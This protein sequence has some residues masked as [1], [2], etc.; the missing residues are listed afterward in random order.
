[1]LTLGIHSNCSIL[2]TDT[3]G[4]ASNTLAVTTFTIINSSGGGILSTQ[5]TSH[6]RGCLTGESFD[7][8]TGVRCTN[9]GPSLSKAFL[10][11]KNLKPGQKNTDI[12]E[13]QKYLNAHGFAV[14]LTGPGSLGNETEFFGP[15]T[16]KALI[17]F[18]EKYA[19]EIL[20]PIGLSKGTGSFATMTR[21]F[22][23]AH[24]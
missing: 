11:T 24:Q 7:R 4:N 14:A 10:F 8:T 21:V 17:K 1:L 22:V 3:A 5:S 6:A 23:N 15:A 16:R 12:K 18:Q 19:K 2:V 9:T 13:L 20:V